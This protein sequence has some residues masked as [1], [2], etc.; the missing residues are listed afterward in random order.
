MK[1]QEP[2]YLTEK[3]S[4]LPKEKETVEREEAIKHNKIN[5]F[6]IRLKLLAVFGLLFTFSMF[7]ICLATLKISQK[8]LKEKVEIQL[9]EKAKDTSEIINGRIAAMFQFFNGVVRMPELSDPN[10]PYEQKFKILKRE[11]SFNKEINDM[12]L[13]DM[14][15]NLFLLDGKIISFAKEEWFKAASKGKN[16]LTEP[17]TSKHDRKLSIIFSTP[18]YDSH[19]QVV[20]VLVSNV[21][22]EWLN[23]LISDIVVGETGGCSIQGL[24][25]TTIAFKDFELVKNQ[26]NA[27]EAA[28]T[29]QKYQSFSLFLKEAIDSP[30]IK[31]GFYKIDKEK[32][33]ASFAKVQSTG[34]NVMVSAPIH[35]FMAS[36]TKAKR[37][38]AINGICILLLTLLVVYYIAVKVV[39]PINK[40]VFA[41]KDI[42]EGEGDLTV[43]LPLKGHDEITEL[44][45]YFNQ[46]IEKIGDLIRS[47]SNN[48][49]SMKTVGVELSSDMTETASTINQINSNIDEVKQQAL[50][51][52]ASVTEM[53]ATI[54][55]II[56]TIRQLNGSIEVQA[57]SVSS[58]SS[59]IEEMVSNIA[60]I[61]QTLEDT[62]DVVVDLANATEEGKS[63]IETSNQVTKQISMESGGLLDATNVIKAKQTCWR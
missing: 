10:F 52:A 12:D 46:T 47:V 17:V 56:C 37:Y 61:T 7:L 31:T 58:S 44:S 39:Q 11:V 54:E 53:V 48:A 49:E 19:H 4:S 55:Q 8:A 36:I 18:I 9:T 3:F 14:Q 32:Y 60:A 41:L 33:I 22:A 16:F 62:N 15:G 45:N 30:E 63:S 59:A 35:E 28:K 26:F 13:I 50:T 38:M 51:Q 34:W 20:G 40:T 25:G 42:A 27:I 1:N 2:F 5:R 23:A 6:S 29:D 24:T 43:R 57:S 21:L